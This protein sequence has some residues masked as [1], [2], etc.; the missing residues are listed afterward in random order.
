M[1]FFYSFLIR[2]YG[3]FLHLAGVFNP[4]AKAWVKGRVNWQDNL[5]HSLPKD[6]KIN[7]FHCASLGEFDQ[8]LPLM[9]ALKEKD[10]SWDDLSY[11]ALKSGNYLYNQ[12]LLDVL[13]QLPSIN[14]LFAN[15]IASLEYDIKKYEDVIIESHTK[16]IFENKFKQFREAGAKV[17]SESYMVESGDPYVEYV[18]EKNGERIQYIHIGTI[19]KK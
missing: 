10:P 18:L 3:A 15:N 4:K 12:I 9:N 11:N 8:G 16:Q 6:R 14:T 5:R 19:E 17:V 1:S 7:W 2:C 13:T